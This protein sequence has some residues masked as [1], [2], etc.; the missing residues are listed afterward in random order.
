M[1]RVGRNPMASSA[2][3]LPD[4]LADGWERALLAGSLWAPEH[5]LPPLLVEEFFLERHRT[6][7]RAMGDLAEQG[8]DHGLVA[9]TEHLRQEGRIEEAGGIASLMA[10]F[11]D[12]WLAVPSLLT[13]YAGR[14]REAATM[15]A[16]R[17][18]GRARAA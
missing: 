8:L 1:A 4:E 5:P 12:G 16:V 17:R 3:L 2:D 13:G 9:V 11:E 14:V 18:L 6:L 10:L 7:W 15:R